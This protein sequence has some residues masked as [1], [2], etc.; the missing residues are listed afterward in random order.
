MK[1]RNSQRHR[2]ESVSVQ[3]RGKGCNSE[4]RG[5]YRKRL[6]QQSWLASVQS[7]KDPSTYCVLFG[8]LS[9]R[10][11]AVS[12]WLKRIC[13]VTLFGMRLQKT[14]NS[15]TQLRIIQR[16][17]GRD[18]GN[19]KAWAHISAP[20]TTSHHPLFILL[21]H[22]VIFT[23][24]LLPYLSLSFLSFFPRASPSPPIHPPLPPHLSTVVAVVTIQRG[25]LRSSV[26]VATLGFPP[27]PVVGSAPPSGPVQPACHDHR[28][29][30]AIHR[31]DIARGLMPPWSSGGDSDTRRWRVC[32]C[33]T[34]GDSVS[35]L[36]QD[37]R[38]SSSDG[39][40][41][42]VW[43]GV[44]LL[45]FRMIPCF[46]STLVLVLFRHFLLLTSDLAL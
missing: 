43:T 10:S 16:K 40:Y 15:P 44:D 19:N 28:Q 22:P 3:D 11:A 24:S 25:F 26:T 35:W 32:G 27:G 36:C 23:L 39:D 12:I 8:L 45:S 17:Q 29:V 14:V 2:Q 42:S 21:H 30:E 34:D 41:Q 38:V 37:E 20:Q 5:R 1:G 33:E 46:C 4:K 18:G 13:W 6:L 7:V 31:I 9:Q